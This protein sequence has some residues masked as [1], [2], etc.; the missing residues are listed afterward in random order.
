MIVINRS[1][2]Q[3]NSPQQS[4]RAS[5][6]WPVREM[7]VTYHKLTEYRL[8]TLF[9][10]SILVNDYNY[11]IIHQAPPKQSDPVANAFWSQCHACDMKCDSITNLLRHLE[12]HDEATRLVVLVS[13]LVNEWQVVPRR[14]GKCNLI[15]F[16]GTSSKEHSCSTIL[17]TINRLRTS[18]HWGRVSL[19]RP[20]DES[21]S[22]RLT[23]SS[24]CVN[25]V[26]TYHR[27]TVWHVANHLSILT[28]SMNILNGII[29]YAFGWRI[30]NV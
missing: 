30:I 27:W 14:C 19:K 21:N 12:N 15:E 29:Q 16:D 17:E 13:T 11:G 9:D 18:G 20:L 5:Q 28:D 1:W 4:I 10:M 8:D 26:Q 22:R 3:L 24:T 25:T 2:R 23:I 6:H 7:N